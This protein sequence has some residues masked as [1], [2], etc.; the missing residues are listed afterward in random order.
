MRP[1]CSA[2]AGLT[3]VHQERGQLGLRRLFAATHKP[4]IAIHVGGQYRR[5]PALDPARRHLRHG[6]EIQPTGYETTDQTTVQTRF[7]AMPTGR[8]RLDESSIV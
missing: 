7:G 1:P 3:G 6:T 8:R 4:R 5:Q 2:I